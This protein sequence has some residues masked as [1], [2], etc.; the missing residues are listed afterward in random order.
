VLVD[1]Y[2]LGNT[3][4]LLNR[5]VEVLWPIDAVCVMRARLKALDIDVP[6]KESLMGGGLELDDLDWLDVVMLVPYTELFSGL[7]VTLP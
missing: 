3:K 6:E 7:Q 2:A 4:A 5:D 1:P